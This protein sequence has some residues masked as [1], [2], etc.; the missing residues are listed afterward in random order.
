M[1]D[2]TTTI[3]A[4]E[5]TGSGFDVNSIFNG[6][7]TVYGFFRQIIDFLKGIFTPVFK[8]LFSSLSDKIDETE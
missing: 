3:A 5:E 1:I 7:L 8:D 2:E 6:I 4:A